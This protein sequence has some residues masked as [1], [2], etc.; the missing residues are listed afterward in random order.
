MQVID[1]IIKYQTIKPGVFPTAIGCVDDFISDV[2]YHDKQ[3]R[4]YF[5]E[6]LL[7]VYKIKLEQ[8]YEEQE[9]LDKPWVP[10]RLSAF[11]PTAAEIERVTE[12]ARIE[13]ELKTDKPRPPRHTQRSGTH[14]SRFKL[15]VK[16]AI[17]RDPKLSTMKILSR[18]DQMRGKDGN[19]YPIPEEWENEMKKKGIKLLTDYYSQLKHKMDV[20]ISRI[21]QRALR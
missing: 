2:L 5:Y 15:N 3:D 6:R 17:E 1:E 9:S 19:K 14:N 21:R 4:T 13:R 8:E 7:P 16:Q 20:Y 18:Y 11:H 10:M 12:L